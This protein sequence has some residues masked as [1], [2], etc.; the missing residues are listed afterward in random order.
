[1]SY[2]RIY[3]LPNGKKFMYVKNIHYW[4]PPEEIVLYLW[5]L[6][7]F[8]ECKSIKSIE[9]LIHSNH[10]IHSIL[11]KSINN[12]LCINSMS[13]TIQLIHSI[14][15]QHTNHMTHSN[16]TPLMLCM[17]QLIHSILLTIGMLTI[18]H[19]RWNIFPKLVIMNRLECNYLIDLW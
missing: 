13:S 10:H 17:M 3:V 7:L 18:T 16:S 5:K 15:I 14:C 1:M 19:I 12:M 9:W 2:I 6:G 4:V 8:I 11:S